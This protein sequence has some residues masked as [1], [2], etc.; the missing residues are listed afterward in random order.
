MQYVFN[1][2]IQDG[3]LPPMTGRIIVYDGCGFKSNGPS[4][5][6]NDCIAA[7]A[8]RHGYPKSEVMSHAARFYWHPLFTKDGKISK[9]EINISP[10]RKIDEEFVYNKMD[11]FNS[12]I[13]EIF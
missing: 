8:R 1:K 7:F 13:D 10:V 2:K 9:K 4:M 6:H 12:V 11:E 3:K 5:D